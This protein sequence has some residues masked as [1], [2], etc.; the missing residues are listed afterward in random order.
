MERFDRR[1]VPRPVLASGRANL[2][3]PHDTIRYD[4]AFD[5]H[6]TRSALS[7]MQALARAAEYFDSGAFRADLARRVAFRTE[8]QVPEQQ[9]MLARYLTDE[10]LPSTER[11][12]F[13]GRIVDNPVAGRGP[14][15]IAQRV[16]GRDLPTVL[17]YGHGDV[18]RGHAADWRAP[19]DPWSIVVEGDRW[20]GRGTADN[21]GQHT[22]NLGALASTLA[23]APT[24][25]SASTSRC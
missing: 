7:R 4:A 24:A 19:L 11:L 20:Y 5:R 17:I 23:R 18:V 13:K 25:V 21:K 3:P 6:E 22:I 14:F 15:L 16:E 9:S 12:G 8:S 10:L 2:S 1:R